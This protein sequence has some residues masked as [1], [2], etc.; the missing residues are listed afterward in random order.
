M[1]RFLPFLL[2]TIAVFATYAPAV[3]DGF[4]WDD[5]A[6]ILRD[7]LIRSPRLIGEGFQHFLFTDA[8]ASNFYRPIQRLTYTL[9]YAAFGLPPAA[10]HLTSI[11]CHLGAAIALLLFARELLRTCGT[12]ERRR[13]IVALVSALIWAIHPVHTSAVVYISGRADPLAGLFGFAAL[14]VGLLSLGA[15]GR[16]LYCL[17]GSATLLFGLSALSKESGLIFLALWLALVV[18]LQRR[19]A[20]RAAVVI[21][22]V[23]VSYVSLR[24]PAEHVAPPPPHKLPL[25]V[26]PI[27]VARAVAE[28]TGILVLPTNLRMERDV[29]THPSGFGT[30]SITGASLRELQNIAGILITAGYGY[31][32]L[33]E[34]KRDRAAFLALVLTAISYIP[35][36][37]II[38]LNAT[39][40]EHWL[41]LPSA[42]LFLAAT[43]SG[44]RLVRAF[45]RLR[46]QDFA[47][48]ALALWMAFLGAR[49]LLRTFDW[50][51][52]RTFLERTI[53]SGSDSARMFINLALVELEEGH[54]EAAKQDVTTALAKDPEQPIAVINRAAIAIRENDFKTARELLARAKE[55]PLVEAR[56]LEMFAVLEFKETGRSN[57]F[58]MRL[59][60][61]SGAEDWEIEKRYV[62][63]LAEMGGTDAA[64]EELRGCLQTQWYRAESWQLLAQLAA[65][66]GQREQAIAALERAHA[67]DIRLHE[68][69]STL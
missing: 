47:V 11:F 30:A 7:P 20:I 54:L 66:S 35:V 46:L 23:L 53:A 33:R 52:Q 5:T 45:P 12:G 16:R 69:P 38:P 32:L 15:S 19:S 44:A 22:F 24:L 25:L 27:L 50:K 43:T 67:Y 28:Y 68:R 6:L 57:I 2:L 1:K 56:A 18:A 14:Y 21:A 61:R 55:M 31:W 41:Y 51:D 48:P 64:V 62:K 3:R 42:F 26:R 49:T 39:V 10:Y 8:T 37:G 58:R 60:S 29:E 13:E 63:L 34:R 36:S 9:E 17:T 4:V 40:A 59:A 65:K